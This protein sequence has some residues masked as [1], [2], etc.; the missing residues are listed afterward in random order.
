MRSGNSVANEG[1]ILRNETLIKQLEE[2]RL[3][4]SEPASASRFKSSVRATNKSGR[5][6]NR[7]VPNLVSGVVGGDRTLIGTS[8]NYASAE[9]C[10][11]KS[12]KHPMFQL[13]F[14]DT[15]S[16]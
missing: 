8:E 12:V 10:K 7:S 11:K 14:S 16:P 9:I 1:K 3:Y 13:K 2:E 5:P 15:V 6:T 4:T